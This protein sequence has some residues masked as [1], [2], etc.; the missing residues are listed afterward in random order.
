MN[1]T[2]WQIDK[3]RKGLNQYRLLSAVNGKLPS[4]AEVANDIMACME[5]HVDE[6]INLASEV[7]RRFAA[8]QSVAEGNVLNALREFL[9]FE[10]V[11]DPADFK[12]ETEDLGEMAFAV[13]YFA[14][15]TFAARRSILELKPSYKT[16][17]EWTAREGL[18]VELHITPHE[19]LPVFFIE[20]QTVVAERD[21]SDLATAKDKFRIKKPVRKGYGFIS[22]SQNLLHVH[23]KGPVKGDR[24]SYVAPEVSHTS[25]PSRYPNELLLMKFGAFGTYVNGTPE[26]H[27]VRR[28]YLF[29]ASGYGFSG[30]GSNA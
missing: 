15:H 4:W 2:F 24:D 21:K 8:G 26:G 1:H 14:N 23:L 12:N 17:I 11:L 6:K 18:D 19:S 27:D 28:T 5:I 3:L 30:D 13:D 25:I 22:T 16:S 9:I 7:L 20:E 10:K 29:T